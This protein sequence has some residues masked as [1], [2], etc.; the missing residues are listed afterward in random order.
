MSLIF[1]KEMEGEETS[2]WGGSEGSVW[3]ELVIE[4]VSQWS[5]LIERSNLERKFMKCV[6]EWM[7]YVRRVSAWVKGLKEQV[8][9][10]NDL[11][12]IV[13]DRGKLASEVN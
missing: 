9:G 12:K 6:G 4:Q 5:R 2:G 10:V 8:K 11:E 7:R 13:T 3:R 1:V